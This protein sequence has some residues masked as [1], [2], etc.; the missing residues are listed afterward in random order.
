MCVVLYYIVG[1]S[2]LYCANDDVAKHERQGRVVVPVYVLKATEISGLFSS[3]AASQS[4]DLNGMMAECLL[5]KSILHIDNA[6]NLLTVVKFALSGIV[7]LRSAC[8]LLF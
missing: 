7:H 5:K 8:R 1:H 6:L 2:V 4:Q 3:I